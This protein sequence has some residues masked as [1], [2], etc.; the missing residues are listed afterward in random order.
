MVTFYHY[1]HSFVQTLSIT[2]KFNMKISSVILAVKYYS[3]FLSVVRVV[4][5]IHLKD[6]LK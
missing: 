6:K 1:L 4:N 3:V 5:I 2:N